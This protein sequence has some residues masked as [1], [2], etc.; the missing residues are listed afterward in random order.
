[1]NS[2]L[3]VE[4]PKS[5]VNRKK[6]KTSESKKGWNE[7]MK[8][9]VNVVPDSLDEDGNP[10]FSSIEDGI[11]G[12]IRG[13]ILARCNKIAD[14]I[15]TQVV[16]D[17]IEPKIGAILTEFFQKPLQQTDMY[18]NKKGESTSLV[19]LVL[20]DASEYINQTVNEKGE[21]NCYSSEKKM[22]RLEWVSL[23]AATDIVNASI[24]KQIDSI[25]ES[26]ALDAG[27]KVAELLKTIYA[28]KEE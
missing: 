3:G 28:R 8:I 4:T 19:E 17:S 1:L 24:K 20:K 25:R 18:G 16:K 15:V 6:S 11:A 26:I 13:N 14:G 10:I 12:K 27:K 5:V 7:N 22:S 21:R 23:K 2:R 9:E